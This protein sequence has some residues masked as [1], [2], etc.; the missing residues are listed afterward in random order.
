MLGLELEHLLRMTREHLLVPLLV[1]KPRVDQRSQDREPVG[2]R[3]VQGQ[4]LADPHAR[5]PGRDRAEGPAH[6]G[7]RVG[8]GIVGLQVARPALEPDHQCGPLH[9]ARSGP[10]EPE[11]RSARAARDS[12]GR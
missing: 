1:A 3:R 10:P 12:P 7:R 5:R 8:L 2:D 6:L 4:Q 11:A 9:E